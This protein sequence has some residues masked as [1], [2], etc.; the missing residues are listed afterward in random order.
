MEDTPFDATRVSQP[1][2]PLQKRMTWQVL[3]PVR[4]S[5]D[6][7]I[8]GVPHVIV[9]FCSPNT[10]PLQL[11]QGRKRWKRQR[12]GRRVVQARHERRDWDGPAAY[13]RA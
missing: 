4:P 8:L 13:G 10:L 7:C 1:E 3:R 2:V 6:D 11:P 12:V 5:F 9:L